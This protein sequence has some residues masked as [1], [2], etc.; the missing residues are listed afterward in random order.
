MPDYIDQL[1]DANKPTA[2]TG[3]SG[4]ELESA[5]I[6]DNE[7]LVAPEQAPEQSATKPKQSPIAPRQQTQTVANLFGY[8]P[9]TG[10]DAVGKFLEQ[11]VYIPAADAID[12]LQGNQKT[13]DQIAKERQQQRLQGRQQTQAVDKAFNEAQPEPI[14]AVRGAIRGAAESTLNA[15]EFI[16]D[17]A[18]TLNPFR[19]FPTITGPATQI[20]EKDNIFSNKYEWA[21]WDLGRNEVGAKTSVGKVAQDILEFVALAAPTGGFGALRG[22]GTELITTPGLLGKA[23]VLLK[24]GAYGSL[25]S[26][27][28]DL[29]MALRGE[30][31][32]SNTLR[33][34]G[35][36][37]WA[38]PL[39]IDEND[40]GVSVVAKSLAEG[41][42]L[43]LPFS[44][45]ADGVEALLA[46]RRALATATKAGKTED[47]ALAAG[48]QEVQETLRDSMP[49][50]QSG[51][52]NAQQ[53]LDTVSYNQTHHP[54][55]GWRIEPVSEEVL[56]TGRPVT[57]DNIT[58]VLDGQGGLHGIVIDPAA[59]PSEFVDFIARA[60]DEGVTHFSLYTP[61]S[62]VGG[63][64]K[65][66]LSIA[67]FR[68]IA[69]SAPDYAE[70][71]ARGWDAENTLSA[72]EAAANGPLLSHYVLD[73]T[74]ELRPSNQFFTNANEAYALRNATAQQ[75]VGTVP[76]LSSSI[77]EVRRLPANQQLYWFDRQ[78]VSTVRLTELGVEAQL[79]RANRAY[80]SI[81]LPN[82][83]DVRFSFVKQRI[84]GSPNGMFSNVK[85]IEVEF[86]VTNGDVGTHGK[87]IVSWW[88]RLVRDELSPGTVVTNV[89][90]S[91]TYGRGN[92][93]VQLRRESI[94]PNDR[95]R[96]RIYRRMGF[97]KGFPDLE[98]YWKQY[99]VVRF[100]PTGSGRFLEPLRV[101]LDP[102]DYFHGSFA[103][104]EDIYQQIQA[105]R[106]P[107]EIVSQ[108]LPLTPNNTSTRA[109]GVGRL[110]RQAASG[111][112][113]TW[114]DVAA[115]SPELFTPGT[116]DISQLSPN[117]Q[118]I[119]DSLI[120]SPGSRVIYDP[121]AQV[122]VTQGFAVF[123]DGVELLDD[124][125]EAIQSFFARHSDIFSREDTALEMGIRGENVYIRPVRLIADE[126]EA[127][128]LGRL[129]DQPDVWDSYGLRQINTY[130]ADNLRDTR[131][132]HLA[133]T[134]GVPVEP[135]LVT[136]TEAL[137]DQLNT[138]SLLNGRRTSRRT[139]TQAQIRQ[140]AAATSDGAG[141]L[142]RR[143]VQQNPIDLEDLS[144]ISRMSEEDIVM[145]AW[146]GMQDA[147]G[148]NFDV[149]MNQLLTQQVGN[150]VLLSRAGIVQVRGLMQELANQMYE[151]AGPLMTMIDNN[152][153]AI[154]AFS[155]LADN[156][157]ALMRVHKVSANVYGNMLR[158]YQLPIPLLGGSITMPIRTLSPE[159][160][161][162]EIRNVDQQLDGIVRRMSEA[163]PEARQ[164]GYRL[165]NAL[166]LAEGDVSKMA[167][168]GKWMDKLVVGK[169][170]S[171]FYNS[172]L[173]GP[174]TQL[175]N[176]V[177]GMV[178]TI[179]R[180]IAA[181]TGGNTS[182]KKAAAAS[183]YNFSQT[184]QDAFEIGW[185]SMKDGA[186][187]DGDKGFIEATQADLQLQI[188]RKSAEIS[189]DI[190]FKAGVGLIDMMNNVANFPL[191]NWPSKLLTGGDEFFKTMVSRME[192]NSRTMM[193]TI[194]ESAGSDEPIKEVFERLYK[195]SFDRTFDP[196][197]GRILD[198]DLLGVAKDV[199]FQGDLEGMA[200]SF[201]DFVNSVP[202]MKIFF[203]F[204]KTGHNILV[205]AGTH[206]PVL[207]RYL[208]EYKAVMAGEDEY[209]KA[210]MRGRQAWGTMLVLGAALASHNGMITGNGPP[211]PEERKL[212]LKQ[213]PARSIRVGDS[214][215]DYSRIEPFGWLLSSVADLYDMTQ[216]G[217]LSED[218]AGYLAGYLTYAVAANFTNKSYMQGVVP[219]GRILTPGWQGLETLKQLPVDTINNFL[220]LA[221]V[222]STFANMLTPYMQEYNEVMDRSLFRASAGL[223][224]VGAPMYD[225]LDGT[226]VPN[227]N[228]GFNAVNPLAIRT[229]R[230]DIVRDALE[231][232]EF[233][234][235]VISKTVSKVK[236]NREQRSRMQQIMGNSTLHKELEQ[237]IKHPNF[238]KA[239][240]DFRSRLEAGERVVKENEPFYS[241]IVRI[242]ERH[243][244]AAVDQ[245]KSEF[246]ELQGDIRENQILRDSQRRPQVDSSTIDL[247][248]IVN[249]PN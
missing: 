55:R 100:E 27:P 93:D 219:L 195:D 222:R 205:Y 79:E 115:T 162:R 24:S 114:D 183:F 157:K 147:L 172:L 103:N 3:P 206:V 42:L 94:D 246:P 52:M 130:G 233:D 17:A 16:G 50:A 74:G 51:H 247:D 245:V 73:L 44:F 236:L 227:P 18:Q 191:F 197:T 25:R 98:G 2:P 132:Q 221:G 146:R 208:S 119:F 174:K 181:A 9:A 6:K 218:R 203:P 83:T 104:L 127:T 239:V 192:Y 145:D 175:T 211:D 242:I 14:R 216:R 106:N 160:L 60:R 184:M 28:A 107:Y 153:D 179:Y 32:I 240:K 207:G 38:T 144:D 113:V 243:R 238:S 71:R 231:D 8:N 217:R 26:A 54:T 118:A 226:L 88:N 77:A 10:L 78:P 134:Y 58:A 21:R 40:S 92:S 248:R 173:A 214:W 64:V 70:L 81:T 111:I 19:M 45:A 209:A 151:S 29:A 204:V 220:P 188:L 244:D 22:V 213:H 137:A 167:S 138:Q 63:E 187:N 56:A 89:P 87:R 232:I 65:N 202:A 140:I 35:L 210:V 12:N 143:M 34:A 177:S 166:V 169:G 95:I 117:L 170:L 121:I 61:G 155:R 4:A 249:M 7:G 124:S 189:D 182:V 190:G 31:G 37:N 228:A 76:N 165:L 102:N 49:N 11:N 224:K 139:V 101:E 90:A 178:N 141:N 23:G 161:A 97:S 20:P 105:Q 108:V 229:R 194:E 126:Q 198:D 13:P 47:E 96:E 237:W 110:A 109:A 125:D 186:V 36:P 66:I 163:D 62:V 84:T 69:T 59:S 39:A 123:I 128:A 46:G 152:V 196:D 57:T 129:F 149:D 168:L 41:G 82:G 148:E 185:R 164:A 112:P 86:S 171:I 176:I 193:K 158:A 15:A 99:A 91:N 156:L 180:P 1:F 241:E 142:L 200:K 234:N 212:W 33:E 154:P 67:S 80:R 120:D 48:I 131:G 122:P 30:G 223:A 135:R 225:W 215:I 159:Q 235:T 150:D 201:G 43:A 199:T 133:S 85:A 136:P 116:R 53:Y 5:L 75:L 68:E 72:E 230:K